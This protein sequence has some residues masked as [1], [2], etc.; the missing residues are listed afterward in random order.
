MKLLRVGVIGLGVGAQHILA[1]AAHS[2]C[3]VVSL[4]DI[5]ADKR[6]QFAAKY[7]NML[8]T[9]DAM[10]LLCDPTID[11]VSIAT[12]DD[13]HAQ[14][15]IAA[16]E[17][18]KHVFVEKPLCLHAREVVAIRQAL[19]Q[20]PHLKLG[21]NLILRRSPRFERIKQMIEAG[22]FGE[23]YHVQGEYNYGRLEKITEGWR[24]SIPY[25]SVVLGGAVHLIDQLL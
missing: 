14:Q 22:E 8:V 10:Q 4:C 21:S 20:R 11:V 2:S 7:P 24:G 16:F 5:D 19:Q 15:I 18:E 12:Y 25:Y 9:D 17:N 6:K 3:E 23:L 1:Y 13:V